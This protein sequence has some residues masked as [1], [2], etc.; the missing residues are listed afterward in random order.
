MLAGVLL[1]LD[2]TVAEPALQG[3]R[4]PA[5]GTSTIDDRRPTNVTPRRPTEHGPGR[6]GKVAAAAE[7][8]DDA[9]KDVH[10]HRV[11]G[12]VDTVVHQLVRT[13][14]ARRST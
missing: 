12:R 14:T 6:S 5:S 10:G 2:V 13:L 1:N 7:V 3:S 9:T 11:V 4:D 8:A